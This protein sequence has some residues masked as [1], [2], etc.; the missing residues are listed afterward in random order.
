V[1][2]WTRGTHRADAT[3]T[4]CV[5]TPE[6]CLAGWRG[7][8]SAA[9]RTWQKRGPGTVLLT[10][11]QREAC[12]RW[13]RDT[14]A[15]CDSCDA[16]EA[17]RVGSSGWV[18]ETSKKRQVEKKERF[19]TGS[20]GRSSKVLIWGDNWRGS[21]WV[22]GQSGAF[23]GSSIFLVFRFQDSIVLVKTGPHHQ[24]GPFPDD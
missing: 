24:N 2:Q 5:Q 19:A 6:V 21:H 8:T 20:W 4:G 22:R 23:E 15:C 13:V 11:S 14:I 10:T 9:R 16:I 7:R 3:R 1:T 18:T 12:L 17:C